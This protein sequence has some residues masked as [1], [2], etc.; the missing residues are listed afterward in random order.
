MKHWNAAVLAG[1]MAAWAGAAFG[2]QEKQAGAEF[3]YSGS[4]LSAIR[5]PAIIRG[6]KKPADGSLP[7]ITIEEIDQCVGQDHGLQGRYQAIKQ[8]KAQFETERAEVMDRPAELEKTSEDIKARRKVVEDTAVHL[9]QVSSELARR[10]TAIEQARAQH[11]KGIELK[12]LGALIDAYNRDANN[13]NRRLVDMKR[14]VRQLQD[15]VDAYN[16]DVAQH[17]ERIDAFNGRMQ[18]YRQDSTAYNEEVSAYRAKCEGERT[19]K[20]A[21]VTMP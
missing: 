7:E 8:R 20:K 13:N 17:N 19:V 3:E 10:R 11:P 1:C 2:G 16:Q 5:I 14:D 18:S 4:S 21:S 9:A 12:A 15:K 6:W